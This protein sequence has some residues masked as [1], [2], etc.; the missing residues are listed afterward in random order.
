MK[1]INILVVAIVAIFT[2]SCEDYLDAP[3]KS[4]MGSAELFSSIEL[5]EPA[6]MGIIQSFGETN[7]YRGRLLP[8][9]GMNTDCEWY[10][11][12]DKYPDGKADLAVYATDATNSQMNDDKNAWAK[13][14]EGIE[15]A[16]LCIEGL[17]GT[18]KAL[19]GTNFGH[20]L[21]EA[22]TL[23]AVLYA[24]LTR[25]WGD[26]PARFQPLTTGTMYIAKSDRDVI[27]KQLI[28]DLGEAEELAFWPNESDFTT[29]S[30]RINKAFIKALR[31]RICLVAGGYSQRPDSDV[32][33]LSTDP[34]LERTKMYTLAKQELLDLYGNT[35]AGSLE[36][37]F[38]N[39]FVKLCQENKTAG[40]ESLWEIPLSEGRG[41]MA[42]T[43]AVKHQVIDQYTKLVSGGQVGPTPNLFY[44]YDLADL[45]RDVTC[46]PY[47]WSKTNPAKQEM[48]AL[49]SWC[50]GKYRYEWMTRYV[51]STNDDGLKKQYMR[52]SEVV[53]MLAE[54]MNEL[55]G[56]SA[57]AP[58]LKAIRNRAFPAELR[59]EKVENYV[60]SL[61]TK[62]AMFDAIV[63][64]HKFEF[65]G[66]MIRKEA[67]IR[68]NL[69]KTKIDIAKTRMYA[70]RSQTGEYSD[71]PSTVYYSY[72]S[73]GETLVTYG[74]NRGET[75]NKST[76][77]DYSVDWVGTGKLK[78]EKIEAIYAK[79]PDKHQFWPIWK[80]FIDS[81]NGMLVNDYG[82]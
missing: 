78:D 7:S 3:T 42:Y 9:Y 48:N 64:E 62:E 44:D 55:E 26:V 45:R 49:N 54:V 1:K 71:V 10:N 56:P 34:D 17:R 82:Y 75:L 57:A 2:T 21:A 58:Y 20:L 80:T 76:E 81:S 72:A 51:T 25:A 77:Y 30:G 27:Y 16:N 37:S 15:R 8:W 40:G 60:N 18:G 36:P 14:Y 6:V 41:R 13:M 66:E 5:A 11:S 29:T 50:F 53:L 70:L 67:L 33:R 63:E 4:S 68:W 43:F 22:I 61:T 52:F 19:P 28:A 35:K 79:D 59:Q 12:S 39:I 31:A 74:L 65:A 47:I 24:D 32:P 73:D 69:L 46:V 23:R 38:K